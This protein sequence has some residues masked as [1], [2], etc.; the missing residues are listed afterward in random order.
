MSTASDAAAS[1]ASTDA[2]ADS[3]PGTTAR[4]LIPDAAA[5]RASYEQ[6]CRPYEVFYEEVILPAI[7]NPAHYKLVFERFGH[8]G[9]SFVHSFDADPF[10]EWLRM[11][12]FD[13]APIGWETECSAVPNICLV[14][15]TALMVMLAERSLN[16]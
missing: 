4:S 2:P 15:G 6:L 10:H 3:V 5:A 14:N 7:R 13:D 8:I 9:F 11:K 16:D 12:L 1:A